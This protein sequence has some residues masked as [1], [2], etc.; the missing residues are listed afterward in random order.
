MS[1]DSI[2]WTIWG[3]SL[4]V[5]K[6]QGSNGNYVSCDMIAYQGHCPQA[7]PT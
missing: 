7:G 5:R 2:S 4:S 1:L 3:I 6:R